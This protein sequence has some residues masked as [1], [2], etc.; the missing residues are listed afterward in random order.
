MLHE[1]DFKIWFAFSETGSVISLSGQLY[2]KE[3]CECNYLLHSAVPFPKI[4]GGCGPF[5]KYPG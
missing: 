4:I 2:N 5:F 1:D 3:K